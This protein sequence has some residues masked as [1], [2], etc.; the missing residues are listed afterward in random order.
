MYNGDLCAVDFHL[1]LARASFLDLYMQTNSHDW[2]HTLL[3][4]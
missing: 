4:R 1:Q 3:C 2:K